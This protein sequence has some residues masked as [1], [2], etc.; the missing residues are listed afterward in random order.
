MKRSEMLK[1][2]EIA[3]SSETCENFKPD[4]LSRILTC[5]EKAGFF[6]PDSYYNE[7]EGIVSYWE[8]E[9][10]EYEK[11]MRERKEFFDNLPRNLPTCRLNRYTGKPYQTK[12][13]EMAFMWNNGSTIQE[14]ADKY[15]VTRTRVE[16][17][18]IKV[19]REMHREKK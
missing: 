18:L 13:H 1:V 3:L 6:P 19:E 17:C 12:S 14:I 9:D 5:L 8:M 2:L 11:M 10:D 7:D 4:S 15:N 16:T